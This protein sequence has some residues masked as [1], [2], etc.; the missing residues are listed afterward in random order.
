MCMTSPRDLLRRGAELYGD[1]LALFSPEGELTYRELA[2][3][4]SRLATKLIS[5]G[6]DSGVQVALAL[7]N[8]EAFLV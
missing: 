8:S 3:K 5:A 1:S 6:I 4:T 7:P 2:N